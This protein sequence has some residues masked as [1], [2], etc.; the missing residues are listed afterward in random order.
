MLVEID[1]WFDMQ[2]NPCDQ[3]FDRVSFMFKKNSFSVIFLVA[4]NYVLLNKSPFLLIFVI[5]IVR[6]KKIKKK[7][8]VDLDITT[9]SEQ[10]E[11]MW[12][13]DKFQSRLSLSHTHSL[14]HF[15]WVCVC[16]CLFVCVCVCVCVVCVSWTVDDVCVFCLSSDLEGRNL[17]EFC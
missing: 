9:N 13:R 3:K 17:G 5:W 16:V 11:M 7:F 6:R 4:Q 15:Q 10:N 2:V 12:D 8:F 1:N 14:T